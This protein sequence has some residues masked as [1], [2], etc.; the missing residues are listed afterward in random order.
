M[1]K[2][3][4]VAWKNNPITQEVF[5]KIKQ[6]IDLTKEDLAS[7][8]GENP[9]SDRFKVGAIGAYNDLLLIDFEDTK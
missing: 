7:S 9:L 4:F 1:T 8:A 6:N 3:E 5:K 2:D